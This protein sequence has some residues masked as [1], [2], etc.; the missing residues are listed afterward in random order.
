[1]TR[2]PTAKKTDAWSMNLFQALRFIQ[3]LYEI[4]RDGLITS[5]E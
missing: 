5:T 1:M 3:L 2:W 4:E